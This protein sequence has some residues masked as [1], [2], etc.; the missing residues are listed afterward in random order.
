MLKKLTI[1]ALLF[2][3][4]C[5]HPKYFQEN[6]EGLPTVQEKAGSDNLIIFDDSPDQGGYSYAY[7]EESSSLSFIKEAVIR[8]MNRALTDCLAKFGPMSLF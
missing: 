4:A 6:G 7:P 1:F 2:L 5:V 3:F 8:L